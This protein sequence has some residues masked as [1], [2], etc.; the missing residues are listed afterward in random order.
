MGIDQ[1]QVFDYELT[2]EALCTVTKT[3]KEDESCTVSRIVGRSSGSLVDS[4]RSARLSWEG[5]GSW[6]RHEC[7]SCGIFLMEWD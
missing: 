4:W 3:V 7:W 5:H 6:S 1:V 2:L